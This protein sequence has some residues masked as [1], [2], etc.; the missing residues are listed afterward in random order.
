MIFECGDGL[1]GEPHAPT[2]TRFGGRTD[3]P[4][5]SLFASRERA[6]HEQGG[7]TPARIALSKQTAPDN[8]IGPE[9]DLMALLIAG[10]LLV[11]IAWYVWRAGGRSALLCYLAVAGVA[12]TV[13]PALVF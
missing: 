2:L 12:A 1:A 11:V 13:G 10:L 3:Y 5:V 4:A 9:F 8:L 6:P 7:T